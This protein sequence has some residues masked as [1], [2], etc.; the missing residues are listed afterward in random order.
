MATALH[1]LRLID[2]D[3][4]EI[5][6]FVTEHGELIDWLTSDAERPPARFAQASREDGDP[7]RQPML[8]PPSR[9]ATAEEIAQAKARDRRPRRVTWSRLRVPAGPAPLFADQSDEQIL[10]MASADRRSGSFYDDKA[11][12]LAWAMRPVPAGHH[13]LQAWLE[14]HDAQLVSEHHAWTGY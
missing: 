13:D 3:D 11:N 7:D 6:A 1:L 5:T 2:L 10:Q 12:H 8:D 9:P 14:R 4:R